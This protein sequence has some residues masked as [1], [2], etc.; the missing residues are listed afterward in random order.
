MA[1]VLKS[2][3]RTMTPVAIANRGVT[4]ACRTIPPPNGRRLE[5]V[6]DSI[7]SSSD[8]VCVSDTLGIDDCARKLKLAP[9]E[10]L[11]TNGPDSEAWCHYGR[12]GFFA[13]G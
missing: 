9:I 4:V 3:M 11:R 13:T 7:E 10:N 1:L 12:W 8:T 6:V 5:V 2:S